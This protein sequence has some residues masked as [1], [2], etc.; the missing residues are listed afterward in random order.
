M[1]LIPKHPMDKLVV[2]RAE[3]HEAIFYN[4]DELNELFEVFISKI[5]VN[6]IIL[7]LHSH[8]SKTSYMTSTS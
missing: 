5:I 7:M 4:A 8:T 6:C 1:E 2:P 3:R